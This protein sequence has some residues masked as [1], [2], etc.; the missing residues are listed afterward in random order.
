YKIATNPQIASNLKGHL[1]L[2]HGDIDN[3]VHP[4]NTIRVVDALIKANK[5]FDLLI[6]PGQRH[7][8]GDM[9]EYFFY[10]MAD[11]FSEWL[12]GSTHRSE[13]DIKQLNND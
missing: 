7:G 1:M 6:L 11:Y 2:V 13:V 5:R 3:N 10:R 8:F 9:N 4:A 12:L